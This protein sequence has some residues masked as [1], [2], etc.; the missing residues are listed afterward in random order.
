MKDAHLTS[1]QVAVLAER[2]LSKYQPGDYQILIDRTGIRKDEDG[3]WEV[4][5]RP[6]NDSAPTFDWT[7]RSAEAAADLDE[8]EGVHVLFT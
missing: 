8:A 5:I 2:Y 7:G 4:P 1:D 6:S 3:W